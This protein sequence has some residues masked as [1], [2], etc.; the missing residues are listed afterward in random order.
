[1][2]Y[3]P[4]L[5]IGVLVLAGVAVAGYFILR[6]FF[7]RAADRVATQMGATLADLAGRAVV[8]RAARA[9]ASGSARPRSSGPRVS[10]FGAYAKAKGVSEDQAR[11]EFADSIERIARIMDGAVRLPVIGP[12][13]LDAVLG[14]FPVAG[15]LLSG[16]IAVSLIGKSLRYGVPHDVI[17]RMLA[18]VLIDVLIGALPVAGDIADMWFRANTRNVAILR[19]YLESEASD[20]IDVTAERVS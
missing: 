4:A 2:D 5:L 18:N 15:D 3:L 8:T 17:A 9:T 7:E 13:G 20:I 1:M 19:D 11:R 12:V 10:H 14:L 6:T 16:A